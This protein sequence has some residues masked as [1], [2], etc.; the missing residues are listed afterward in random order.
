MPNPN[1]GEIVATTQR[2]RSGVLADNVTK[3][4]ALWF[5]LNE[6]GNV[7][8]FNGGRTI[9][10]ELSYAENSTYKRY[11]GLDLLNVNPSNVLDGADFDIKQ[12]SM[13]VV[14]SGLEMLQNAGEEQVIDLLEGRIENAEASMLNGMTQDAYSDGTADGGK[15]IG[16]LQLLVADAP[17]SATIGGISQLAFPFWKNFV[18]DCTSDGTGSMTT[19]NCQDYMTRVYLAVSR[20]KDQPDL[21]IADNNYWRL[22]NG[23]LQPRQ[24]IS[25]SKLADAGFQNL[26]FMGAD[27]VFDGG[28][29]GFCPTNHMYFLNTKYLRLRPHANQNMEPLAGGTRVPVQQDAE[30]RITGWAGNMT[31]RGL[32]YQGL[33]KD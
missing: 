32:Q 14:I 17:G 10:E 33:I 1:V 19:A 20:G 16:G 22:Y 31:A 11:S 15:Q 29:G 18:F 3:N 26:K 8:P 23:S 4:N 7:K 2:K 30:I 12:A 25:N 27:V 24:L 13:S 6:K 5:R 21:I 28:V 9:F